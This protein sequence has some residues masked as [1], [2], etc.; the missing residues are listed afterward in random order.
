MIFPVIILVLDEA[1]IIV[2]A[3]VDLD[4]SCESRDRRIV[5]PVDRETLG[6]L[7][8]WVERELG[9]DRKL[10]IEMVLDHLIL[11]LFIV[12]DIYG[13][14]IRIVLTV[15]VI[16]IEYVVS[17]LLNVFEMERQAFLT[18]YPVSAVSCDLLLGIQYLPPDLIES[19]IEGID[20]YLKIDHITRIYIEDILTSE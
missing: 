10:V 4:R 12:L 19:L 8:A 2:V 9:A 11:E 7:D 14:T 6:G 17:R 13:E 20:G 15:L 16:T 3:V 1:A 5:V 18:V